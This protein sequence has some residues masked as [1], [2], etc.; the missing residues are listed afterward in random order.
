MINYILLNISLL[1]LFLYVFQKIK[2]GLHMLQ[3]EYYKNDRYFTW[4]KKNKSKVFSIRDLLLLIPVALIIVNPTIALIIN[5]I[6]AVLLYLSR[7]IYKEKKPLVETGRIKRVYITEAIIFLILLIIS[8]WNFYLLILIDIYVV[9]AYYVVIILNSINKPIEKLIQKKFVKKAKTK[10]KQMDK[11]KIIGITGSYGKT[12]M[13]YIVSTI[14]NQKF[15]VLKT[16]KSYNTKMGIVRTIN[17]N[18][19]RTDQIFICEMGADEVGEIK[20]LCD[21]V[22]P[23][24][25]VITSIGPQHLETFGSLENIKKTKFELV[26]SLPED[27]IAFLNYDDENVKSVET[28]KNKITYG[29]KPTNNYYA[30]NIKIGE[31][32]SEFVVNM[33]EKGQISINTKLLGEHNII[34]IVGAVAIAKELGLTNEQIQLGIKQLKPVEHRLELKSYPNGTIIIDDAYNSNTKGA[35]MAVEVLGRFKNRKRILVTPGIVELG[36]KLYEY[37]KRFGSQA[38]DNCDYVILVGEKQAKPIYDGLIEKKFSKDKIYIAKNFDDAKQKME[39]IL[40]A[41][42]VILLENDLTDNYL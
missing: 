9:F 29:L 15:N 24:I 17:E 37:N 21:L 19:K 41:T 35:Q 25:G 3:L 36:D 26:E 10:L 39:E 31:F 2:H 4:M 40:D 34:N 13:K 30:T 33:K 6:V 14:L 12:S 32:G 23:S 16:P 8:N 1:I 28:D 42:S 18:L 27:G 22:H 5:I 20:E 11:L 7:N 38:A